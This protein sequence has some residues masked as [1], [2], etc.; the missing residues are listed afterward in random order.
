MTSELGSDL[1][2]LNELLSFI[3][4]PIYPGSCLVRGTIGDYFGITASNAS[5]K[6]IYDYYVNEFNKLGEAKVTDNPPDTVF[7]GLSGTAWHVQIPKP[8]EEKAYK[9]YYYE[10]YVPE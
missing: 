1:P 7:I 6:E 10:L 5:Y 4:V 8:E 2:D 9:H 3:K